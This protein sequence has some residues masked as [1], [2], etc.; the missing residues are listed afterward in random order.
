[1]NEK[2]RATA[3]ELAHKHLEAGDPLGWFE[4]LYSRAGQD[5]RIIPWADLK[6]NPNLV[7]WLNQN[8]SLVT[9]P[10]LKIG[11]G[12]GD[13][14]EELARRGLETIAFD[15]SESAIDWTRKRFPGSSVS[16]LVANLFSAPNGWQHKFPFVLESY[17]LQVL[18]PHLRAEAVRC[19][20]SLLAPSGVL[21]V[22]ARAREPNEPEGK[23][24]WP[25]T[26]LELSLFQTHGLNQLTFEDYIDD[27]EPPVRRFR[28]TFTRPE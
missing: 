17:T 21:L 28:S 8:R 26:K 16:Y 13:D 2:R 1:M 15:I 12:L 9:G 4:E 25:V 23:M 14:A 11:S 5:G 27:E 20:S 10:A 19:I 22:I 7:S 24:P 3:R 6:P 18:P